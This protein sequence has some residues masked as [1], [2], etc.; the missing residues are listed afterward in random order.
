[1]DS[2]DNTMYKY[3]ISVQM[4]NNDTN[5]R[6]EYQVQFTTERPLMPPPPPKVDLP[7]KHYLDKSLKT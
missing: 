5:M 4:Y 3:G 6:G 2:N 7:L 1:M